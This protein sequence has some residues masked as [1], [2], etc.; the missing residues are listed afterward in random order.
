[1]GVDRR[2]DPAGS[3]PVVQA[4]LALVALHRDYM[5]DKN[6]AHRQDARL[7]IPIHARGRQVQR[8]FRPVVRIYATTVWIRH[9]RLQKLH[10]AR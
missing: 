2:D 6:V 5:Q 3:A 4:A 1:M 8:S 10:L 7:R 9:H